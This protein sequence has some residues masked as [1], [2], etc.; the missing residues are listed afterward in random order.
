MLTRRETLTTLA[1]FGIYRFS[2]LNCPYRMYKKLIPSHQFFCR[3]AF[4][5]V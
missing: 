5:V 2:E 1:Q 4:L 3:Q